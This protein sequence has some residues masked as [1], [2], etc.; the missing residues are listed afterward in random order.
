MTNIKEV[1]IEDELTNSYLSYAMSV[2]V[3]RA[4][5]DI[6]DGL[7]PVHR[8]ILYAMKE[9]ENYHYKPYKKSA[10]VVGDVIGK[11]HPHGESAVYE[12]IV[13]LAQDFVQRYILIDG[14]GNF[15]S[16]DGDSA[17]AM[18]YTE[19]RM[20]ELAE[21]LIKDLDY[22]TVDYISN[23]DNT[24]K[25]PI[26]LPAKFPNLLVNGTSGIAVGMATNIPPHNLSEIINGCLA[27]IDDS[28]LTIEDLM[29]YILGPD[30][31]TKAI[32]NG[33][34]GI[35]EAY[36]TGKGKIYIRA[37]IEN[38]SDLL[39]ERT[40]I[41]IT[42]L[43]YQVNK[44]RLIERIT[45][46]IKEKKIIGIKTLR[47]ESDKDGLRIFIELHKHVNY[48]VVLNNLYSLSQLEI[49]FGINMV[50]LVDNKPKLL[51]LKNIIS[52]F[53][54]HRKEIVYRKTLFQLE[55]AR[56]KIHIIE[57][58]CIAILNIDLIVDLIR[59]L[60][61]ISDIKDK[62]S[63]IVWDKNIIVN[64]FTEKHLLLSKHPK[65]LHCYSD[66]GYHFSS[67]QIQSILDLKLYRLAKLEKNKLINEYNNIIIEIKRYLDIIENNNCLMQEIKEELI[68]I[69]EKFGDNRRTEIITSSKKIS[70][71]DLIPNDDLIITLSND[72][73]IKAQL[74]KLYHAQKRG[75]KGKLG[76]L[77]KKNDFIIRLLITN[78]HSTLL[79]F[80]NLG[81]V[82]WIDLYKFKISSRNS[83]GLPIVNLL[84]LKKIEK[85][86]AILSIN[87]YNNDKFVFMATKSGLVK[88]IPLYEFSNQR[89]NGINIIDLYN[90]DLLIGV[91][92]IDLNDEVMLFTKSGK[93]I[94]FSSNDIRLTGR[95]SK[96]IRGIKIK[97]NDCLISLIRLKNTSY[98]LT[99]TNTGYGKKT[100]VQEFPLTKRGGKGVIGIRVNNKNNYVIGV[101][102]VSNN[103]ELI[104]IT[105]KG[106]FSR[107][108]TNEISCIGRLTK[109]VTLIN[110][111]NSD[112]LV[113]IKKLVIES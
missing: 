79:C 52:N 84:P 104:L 38:E 18:R 93:A 16:I 106:V 23:Y 42:E 24:E 80:S 51:N 103:D 32:I 34:D 97:D 72:G 90:D 69:K 50:A 107:I 98:I 39:D 63:S 81:R 91:E 62:L 109:G 68:F 2:I 26:I 74:L 85:I 88:R 14:Q 61:S 36:N 5:P 10:R 43:P 95:A 46:L 57:G 9:L 59:S 89:S 94:R 55:R 86:S 4:L 12:S 87:D 111:F 35:F 71:Y 37:K 75:G 76:T 27:Y 53:I 11:Y 21:Y 58:L 19:I 29:K 60:N 101:V 66:N 22:N 96:G 17:A 25:Q 3:G 49:V 77:I 47:D 31:P 1:N 44:S 110:L 48:L 82:Y 112:Y 70:D 40:N 83:K 54:D 45:A 56:N 15:G 105:N 6:R 108:R 100:L 8:R 73:Y 64:F 33:V 30:F 78:T 67:L 20:S 28:N 41:I 102:T 7:K 13:R 99:A 113:C 92:I 65:F